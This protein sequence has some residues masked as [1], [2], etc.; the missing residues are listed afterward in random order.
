MSDRT[1]TNEQKNE[2]HAII[3]TASA[4]A[5][6]AAAGLAQLPCSDTAVITPIQIAMVTSISQVFDV[7]IGE[8][9]AKSIVSGLAAS[10]GGRLLS[11]VLVGWIPGIGNAI[12]STTAVALTESI[13]WAAAEHFFGIACE[14]ADRYA[15]AF[16]KASEA[17]IRKINYLE[18][19]CDMF[20]E[21]LMNMFHK[22]VMIHKL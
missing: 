1:M 21:N 9:T 17:Y 20:Q 11:Q 15:D 14:T 4:A 22:F 12:N 10:L 8:G 16:S 2:C 18:K 13:G 7:R 3:H 5:G 6:V 19:Q